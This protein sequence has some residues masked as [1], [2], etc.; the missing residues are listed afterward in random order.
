[1][2]TYEVIIHERIVHTITVVA[3]NEYDAVSASYEFYRDDY[4]DFG[5]VEYTSD[6]EGFISHTSTEIKGE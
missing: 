5:I 3:D 2:P 1:M 6:S 4:A